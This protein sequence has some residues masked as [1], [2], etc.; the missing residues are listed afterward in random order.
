MKTAG[1]GDLVIIGSESGLQGAKY[2]SVYCASKFGLRGLAQSLHA[3]CSSAGIRVIN[4]NPGPTRTPFFDRLDFEP[5]SQSDNALSPTDIAKRVFALL[6]QSGTTIPIELNLQV[7][8]RVF[9]KK[10]PR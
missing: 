10:Q 8:K 4:V 2:G 5:G 7:A 9:Q 3:E 6:D 1:G